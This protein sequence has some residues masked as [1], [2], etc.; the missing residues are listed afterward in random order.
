MK[1]QLEVCD[2]SEK[3]RKWKDW[4]VD[5]FA[6]NCGVYECKQIAGRLHAV[7]F[8]QAAVGVNSRECGK[9]LGCFD[10]VA[11]ACAA[12]DCEERQINSIDGVFNFP[13]EEELAFSTFFLMQAHSR[14]ELIP[15]FS[16]ELFQSS[17]RDLRRGQ[18]TTCMIGS[19][20]TTSDQPAGIG[21][22]CVVSQARSD[23]LGFD[24]LLSLF[25]EEFFSVKKLSAFENGKPVYQLS[26]WEAMHE[27]KLRLKAHRLAIEKSGCRTAATCAAYVRSFRAWI[28]IDSRVVMFPPLVA[29]TIYQHFGV[30][31]GS[32]VFDSSGGFGGRMLGAFL[33]GASKYVCC[34]PN[35]KTR[36]GLLELASFLEPFVVQVHE[37]GSEIFCD[38]SLGA[39]LA[40]TSPPYGP[41]EKYSDEASQSS[42]RF[43]TPNEW[44]N[45]F[46]VQ[47]MKNTVACL[48]PGGLMLLNITDN[49]K[50]RAA[51]YWL[52]RTVQ[53][54]D[55]AKLLGWF[56]MTCSDHGVPKDKWSEKVFVFQKDQS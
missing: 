34:E 27:E 24:L 13:W 55:G 30:G 14:M 56:W 46:L 4:T 20:L 51:G 50:L 25:G 17:L 54:F 16:L 47:T 10:S 53:S 21:D 44:L 29:R 18:D 33:A 31:P 8:L 32:I 38:G 2:E 52:E 23:F 19:G 49:R 40:F 1:R 48:R 42:I 26:V 41:L 11:D 28:S 36:L 15:S 43:D 22:L 3:P 37:L 9:F 7:Y 35:T 39:H 6:R 5:S 45:G 12:W